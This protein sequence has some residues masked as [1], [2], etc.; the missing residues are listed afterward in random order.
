M[1]R[2]DVSQKTLA[3]I[4]KIDGIFH[5]RTTDEV[6]AL[7]DFAKSKSVSIRTLGSAH[8]P[9]SAIIDVDKPEQMKVILDGELRKIKAIKPDDAKEFAM[10][11]VG[12]GCYLGKNPSDKSSTLENSFNFQVDQSGYAL[13]TLGGISHQTIAGFLQTSSSGGSAAHGIADVV[14]AI[15]WINGKGEICHA[16]KGEKEFEAVAV[17]M[18]LLGI[19][20]QVTFKL[21]K[22][23]LVQ[24]VEENRELKDSVLAKDSK[25]NFSKLERALFGF[26]D[27]ES[28]EGEYMHVNWLPQK[29]VQRTMQWSGRAVATSNQIKPYEHP[30]HSK[31][32]A[33][34]AAEA[35][36]IGNLIDVF[37]KCVEKLEKLH[38][39]LLQFK[40]EL[41]KLFS[42]PKDRKEF[43][44]VWYKTLPI[45]DQA[46]VDGIIKTSFSELWFPRAQLNE[47]MT[48][49]EALFDK[50]PEAAGNFIVELYCAKQSPYWLSP[51]YGQDAFRVDLYWWDHNI[52]D[53][54]KYFG[55]FWESLLDVPGARLHWGKYLPVP[56]VKYG[57]KTFTAEHLYHNYPQYSA[58]L[59][60]REEMDPQ[61]L[62]VTDYWRRILDIPVLKKGAELEMK[63]AHA[64][65][66]SV[67][68]SVLNVAASTPA[69]SAVSGVSTETGD[70]LPVRIL[71][72]FGLYGGSATQNSNEVVRV[73]SEMKD[74]F[75]PQ[76]K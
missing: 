22:K 18:G 68:G 2:A 31:F 75:Q 17:S 66:A 39:A 53:V 52:G 59:K 25:G 10:V 12:A 30:L 71:K 36:K 35:L 32:I 69:I 15:E 48:R 57:E 51:S 13:P 14:E 49:L 1:L 42:D 34:L 73:S 6:K 41:L 47:V 33:R 26:K 23:Y 8:S 5:P 3:Q 70:Y 61:Q 16:K 76:A 45:D 19:I 43:C 24:G 55:L 7:I 46:D 50:H 64:S 20:T 44:D 74:S 60:L 65:P 67:A 9:Q 40:A 54:N 63:D 4:P 56:G 11:S 38:A 29:G 21:P 37:G 62:F 58:W 72:Y 27:G 28:K